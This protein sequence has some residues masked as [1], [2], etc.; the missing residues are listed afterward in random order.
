M[1]AQWKTAPKKFFIILPYPGATFW[2]MMLISLLSIVKVLGIRWIKLQ[3]S[4]NYKKVTTKIFELYQV[5]FC[6][7]KWYHFKLNP[8]TLLNAKLSLPFSRHNPILGCRQNAGSRGCFLWINVFS[9]L[10][11]SFLNIPCLPHLR[12]L[13]RWTWLEVGLPDLLRRCKCR[14]AGEINSGAVCLLTQCDHSN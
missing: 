14:G 9:F 3:E 11:I 13:C 4:L 8:V 2:E 5:N 6:A 10:N 1:R 12:G 7:I